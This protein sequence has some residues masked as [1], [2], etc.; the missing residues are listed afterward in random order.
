MENGD[1]FRWKFKDMLAAA[2]S[3]DVSL[4]ICGS[5][6][7]NTSK[8]VVPISTAAGAFLVTA[9]LASYEL[10]FPMDAGFTTILGVIACAFLFFM[11]AL[12]AYL[13]IPIYANL[14]AETTLGRKLDGGMPRLSGAIYLLSYAPFISFTLYFSLDIL[15]AFTTAWSPFLAAIVALIFPIGYFFLSHGRP[16]LFW[17]FFGW[18]ITAN[19][20]SLVWQVFL[21]LLVLGFAENEMK[22]FSNI[23]QMSI[24]V[25]VGLATL[26]IHYGLARGKTTK[27][28]WVQAMLFA[29]V[30]L[31]F[32]AGP[33][34]LGAV[35]LRALGIGGH[36]P[37]SL[38]FKE[39]KASENGCLILA[40]PTVVY[41]RS[42][43]V[44]QEP[45]LC[46]IRMGIFPQSQNER[47]HLPLEGVRVIDRQQ[48]I[49][50]R[51]WKRQ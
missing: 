20:F 37:A 38:L 21:Y 14:L 49:E 48:I 51:A 6:I 42:A 5:I 31:T 46:Q 30:G 19:F 34:Y 25:A 4:S 35:S 33:S 43:T 1:D 2:S 11:A 27:I 18:C 9:F 36:V 12:A 41:W 29:M 24:I 7:L 28:R 39:N 17:D 15:S 26:F 47:K 16:A 44:G 23:V 22:D 8:I 45:G 10:P 50:I 3:L 40:T 32:M 13:T